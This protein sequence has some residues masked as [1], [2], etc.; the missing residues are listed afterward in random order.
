MKEPSKRE[1]MLAFTGVLILNLVA[2]LL[3]LRWAKPLFPGDP[4]QYLVGFMMATLGHTTALALIL[5][6]AKE[7]EG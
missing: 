7:T 3:V 6:R 2:G 4:V 1:L 5:E